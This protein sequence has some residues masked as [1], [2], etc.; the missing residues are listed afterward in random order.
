MELRDLEGADRTIAIINALLAGLLLL[1]LAVSG[2]WL[3]LFHDPDWDAY[4]V[5]GGRPVVEPPT[6]VA[7][8]HQA[9]GDLAA[10]LTLW[11]TSWVSYRVLARVS[12]TG[13]AVTAVLV[14][15]I[16]TGSRIRINA[17]VRDG[18]VDADAVG[19][20]QIFGGDYDFVVADRNDFEP[21]AAMFWT[22]LHVVSL[23]I[24][25]AMIWYVVRR[26]R[27]RRLRAPNP[28]PSWLDRLG[29]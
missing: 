17:I 26:S 22:T 15:A 21:V 10:I 4:T 16:V 9:L 13:L 18:V 8:L 12:W 20:A 3:F 1:G 25:V 14:A 11:I 28:D 7:D 29:P 6:G 5:G 27:V 2:V 23:P 19:Y 24:I